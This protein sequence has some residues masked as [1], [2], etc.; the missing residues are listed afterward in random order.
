MNHDQLVA[1]LQQAG[2]F[3]RHATFFATPILAEPPTSITG[4]VYTCQIGQ[5]CNLN[6]NLIGD[7][8][9]IGRYSQTALGSQVGV[10][11]HPTDWL[12]THFF[13]YRDHFEPFPADHPDGLKGRHEEN[14]PTLIGNDVWI[15]SLA[16]VKSG[17]TIGDGAIVAAG[18]VVVKD[19]PPYAIVG[20]VPAKTIRLRFPEAIVERLLKI[21]WW[22]FDHQGIKLLPF[23][24]IARCLDLLEEKAASGALVRRPPDYIRID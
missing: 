8:T 2:I 14:Q 19:V 11:G 1:S 15:G 24:D 9:A 18:A 12:S 21:R 4:A 6:G 5:Y 7:R 13:Q 17:V 23:N 10:G 20:G 22:E 3:A 16:F